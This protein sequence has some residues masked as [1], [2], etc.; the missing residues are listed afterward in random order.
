MLAKQRPF[1]ES[2]LKIAP[3]RGT[4]KGIGM[5]FSP[6]SVVASP[7][8]RDS[9]VQLAWPSFTLHDFLSSNG[10]SVTYDGMFPAFRIDYVLLDKAFAASSYKRLK[11]DISDHYPLIV[12]FKTIEQ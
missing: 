12:S 1:F 11:A 4:K 5:K 8:P 10:L 7:V 9:F 6:H 2:L 3:E